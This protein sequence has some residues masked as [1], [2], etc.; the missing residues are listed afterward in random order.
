MLEYSKSA[1]SWEL[2]AGYLLSVPLVFWS[3]RAAWRKKQLGKVNASEYKECCAF[4]KNLNM[5]L[6]SALRLI[7]KQTIYKSI[8]VQL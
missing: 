8:A 6:L 2:L 4:T 7:W 1:K 3:Q 5:Q